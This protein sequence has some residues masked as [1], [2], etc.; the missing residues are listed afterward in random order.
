MDEMN[1]NDL[2]RKIDQDMANRSGQIALW[3][4][5]GVVALVALSGAI[6]LLRQVY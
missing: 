4:C 3:V 1:E 6:I 2:A 5:L